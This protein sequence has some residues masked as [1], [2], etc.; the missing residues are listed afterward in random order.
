MTY[1][2]VALGDVI[3]GATGTT[4]PTKAPLRKFTYVDVASVDNEQKRIVGAREILGSEAPSRARKLIR[5]NDVLVSTVRPNLNA[6][7]I[8]PQSLDGAVASTGFAVLRATPAVLPE[9]LF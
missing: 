9:F 4:N 7:A 5:C 1:P 3:V 8:V 6:V 2:L